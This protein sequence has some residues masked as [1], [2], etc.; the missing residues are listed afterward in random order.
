[1]AD[2]DEDLATVDDEK[3]DETVDSE[4]DDERDDSDSPE[5]PEDSDEGK[6]AD[7]IANEEFDRKL[8]ELLDEDNEKNMTPQMRRLVRRQKEQ[9][10]RVA[11]SIKDTKTN[12][13]WFLPLIVFLLILGLAWVVVFYVT[14]GAIPIAAIG[15]WNLL[16]G[17]GIMFVGFILTMWWN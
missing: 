13:K 1:M 2:K 11:E 3:K 4:K 9:T 15:N 5:E 16:I 6:S 14:G 17:F 12:P 10:Q 8:D 7:D